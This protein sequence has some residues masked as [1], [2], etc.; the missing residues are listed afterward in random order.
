MAPNLLRTRP[1]M[2]GPKS[3]F[4]EQAAAVLGL[5]R[6]TV[7]YRIR[8]G[9]LK[10]VRT[11]GGTQRVLLESVEDLLREMRGAQAAPPGDQ[12]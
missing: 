12:R 5:S 3:I 4:V 10:T 2:S 1:T 11:R 7:Y 6:R 9:R 8:A